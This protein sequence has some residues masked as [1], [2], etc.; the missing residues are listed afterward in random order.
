MTYQCEGRDLQECDWWCG[1]E[2]NI[3][4]RNHTVGDAVV[5]SVERQKVSSIVMT[6]NIVDISQ[7][8]N[9]LNKVGQ[10]INWMQMARGQPTR[11][12]RTGR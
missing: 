1:K 9:R 10:Q 3:A 12:T 4:I 7:K 6:G 2:D 8:I 11:S 5:E